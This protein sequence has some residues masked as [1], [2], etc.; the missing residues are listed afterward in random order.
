MLGAVSL[1]I[2]FIPVSV[3]LSWIGLGYGIRFFRIN[4][5]FHSIIKR[6]SDMSKI[7]NIIVKFVFAISYV[8]L[9]GFA[10]LGA[11]KL[12]QYLS[13]LGWFG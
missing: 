12:T 13:D 5:K 8:L 1:A 10:M 11:R 6:D 9:F 4:C 7:K 2:M 3:L